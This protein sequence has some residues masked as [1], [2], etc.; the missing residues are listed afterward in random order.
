MAATNETARAAQFPVLCIYAVVVILCLLVFRSPLGTACIVLPLV[1]TSAVDYVL[2]TWLEIGLEVST[3]PMAVR[4]SACG[5]VADSRTFPRDDAA[6]ATTRSPPRASVAGWL[7]ASAAPSR[8]PPSRSGPRPGYRV[9]PR[10][11]PAHLARQTQP[12][13]AEQTDPGAALG[14]R[15]DAN[16][17]MNVSF[18]ASSNTK[19]RLVLAAR[20][21]MLLAEETTPLPQV[22]APPG[23][24]A[25]VDGGAVVPVGA[26]GHVVAVVRGRVR[27]AAV[28][29]LAGLRRDRGRPG[30]S[31]ADR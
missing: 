26:H 20:P 19:N 27:E 8:S 29:A 17:Q 9:S 31:R 15:P 7:P 23:R 13:R 4:G 10:T 28:S 16:R 30:R 21:T 3:L 18:S 14:A 1:L 12:A 11:Q 22:A 2:M 6:G 25:R 5:P 24:R